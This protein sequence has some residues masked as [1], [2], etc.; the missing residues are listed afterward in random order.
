MSVFSMKTLTAIFVCCCFIS[1]W[2]RNFPKLIT[3]PVR[4]LVSCLVSWFF[5]WFVRRSV[6]LVRQGVSL[7]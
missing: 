7:S 4:L 3:P 1:Y 5:Y 2:K 6:A